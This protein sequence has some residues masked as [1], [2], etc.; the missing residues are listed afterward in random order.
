M[1]VNPSPR[2]SRFEP[3]FRA[4]LEQ[5][6]DKHG[7]GGYTRRPVLGAVI[8]GGNQ[9]TRPLSHGQEDIT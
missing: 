5:F 3:G 1:V 8:P 4:I 7:F 2:F 9:H 6:F